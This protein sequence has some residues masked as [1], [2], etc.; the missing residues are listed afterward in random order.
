[1]SKPFK[2][3]KG[4]EIFKSGVGKYSYRVAY[5]DSSRMAFVSGMPQALAYIDFEDE[6]RQLLVIKKLKGE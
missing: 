3:Y 6:R 4:A 5:P 2:V 1:M